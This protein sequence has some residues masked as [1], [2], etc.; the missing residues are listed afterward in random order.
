M[1]SLATADDRCRADLAMEA[2]LDALKFRGLAFIPVLPDAAPALALEFKLSEAEDPDNTDKAKDDEGESC[3][4][5][6]WCCLTRPPVLGDPV[7]VLDFGDDGEEPESSTSEG[8]EMIEAPPECVGMAGLLSSLLKSKAPTPVPPLMTNN[9][10]S[11]L[12]AEED[13]RERATPDPFA[14]REPGRCGCCMRR[15]GVV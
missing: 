11:E 12:P 7:R 9:S 5:I 1:L 6:L 2:S 8:N 13:F 15:L 10:R 4:V 14:A 3:V